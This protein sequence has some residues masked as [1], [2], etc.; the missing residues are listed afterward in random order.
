MTGR[1]L[2]P[3]ETDQLLDGRRAHRHLVTPVD[4]R[5]AARE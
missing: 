3:G 2:D 5:A 1:Q 4:I